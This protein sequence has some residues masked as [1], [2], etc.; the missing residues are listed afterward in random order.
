M[1]T[2]KNTKKKSRVNRR[3]MRGGATEKRANELLELMD[4]LPEDLQRKI[5][6]TVD[7][8]EKDAMNEIQ[9]V[10]DGLIK[11]V[12]TT[13]SYKRKRRQGRGWTAEDFGSSSGGKKKTRRRGRKT[14]GRK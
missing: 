10:L 11:N 8:I 1:A 7:E 14:R 3:R 13:E 5:I 2:R 6:E 9:K 4:K 12:K